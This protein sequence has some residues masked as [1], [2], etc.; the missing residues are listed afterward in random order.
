MT[1]TSTKWYERCRRWGQTNLTEID[2]Q[3]YDADLW[4]SVWRSKK[5]QGIIVNAGGLVAYYPS[6]FEHQYRA[7]FLDG[8]DLF[9]EICTL[10][11][12][13]GLAV[14]ARM[15]SSQGQAAL[16]KEHPDW[17]VQD[18]TGDN[19]AATNQRCTACVNAPYYH[20]YLPSVIEEIA[21]RYK[22]DGFADNSWTG[23]GRKYICYCLNCRE[24]FK[25]DTGLALPESAD[26]EDPVYRAW[27]RWG[28]QCRLDVWE[29]YNAA[30]RKGGGEDCLWLGMV[31]SDPILGHVDFADIEAIGQR[32]PVILCDQQSRTSVG[33]FEQNSFAGKLLHEVSSWNTPVMESMAL[34]V[35][36][37]ANLRLAAAPEAEA[38]LWI[39]EG[40]A[41]GI[42]PWW[43]I[44][45]AQAEDP[46]KLH[47]CDALFDWHAEYEAD[48]YNREPIA[49]VGLVWSQE[50]V[51]FFGR[52]A[53]LE[54][55]LWPLRGWNK[56]LVRKRIPHL[57]V[58]ARHI[59][60][61]I[62][63]LDCLVLP[64]QV[65]LTDDEIAALIAFVENGGSLIA[66]GPIGSLDAN[67]DLRTENPLQ[68]LFG[69]AWEAET[70]RLNFTKGEKNSYLD[71]P[72]KAAD[73]LPSLRDWLGGSNILGFSGT[74]TP[75]TLKTDDVAILAGYVPPFP[76]YPPEFSWIRDRQPATPTITVREH[77]SGGRLVF[78][79]ADIDRRFGAC[80]LPD[81]GE[82][83][84]GLLEWAVAEVVPVR[85]EGSGSVDVHAYRQGQRILVHL[86]NLTAA[87]Q[88]PA[89]HEETIPL[90]MQKVCLHKSAFSARPQK[91]HCAVSGHRL[92]TP[93]EQG[94]WLQWH[95]PEL[96]AHALVI[97][98]A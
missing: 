80:G 23:L 52:S 48:L 1:E 37:P 47:A 19:G 58:H 15:D 30:A 12:E 11:R 63:R 17:F 86:V 40:I 64:A 16:A 18:K 76:A 33:G 60:K 61:Q 65:V 66:S 94:D 89:Y 28:Y 91:A 93:V 22:P 43:H 79:A 75:V 38:A 8:R 56:A 44:V 82:V 13:E 32:T 35:R 4:R 98:E 55:V 50:N 90:G 9:G 27:I 3:H 34:Y 73:A 25:R 87:N 26:F 85:V 31:N 59:R 51:D 45:G 81:H 42:S 5:T 72:E 74:L 21:A 54:N 70:T 57:P 78:L 10:A 77:S 41:G 69:L 97:I 68:L 36:E 95:L 29:R 71:L 92:G 62:G 6:Q 49:N 7:C 24:K 83:L 2:A 39:T 96:G 53:P 84:A 20:T 67:G 88:W 14:I 46:R